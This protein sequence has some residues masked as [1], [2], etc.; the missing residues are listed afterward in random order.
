MFAK[1]TIHK[2]DQIY[3]A[4]LLTYEARLNENI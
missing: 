2:L 4:V 1:S 3:P